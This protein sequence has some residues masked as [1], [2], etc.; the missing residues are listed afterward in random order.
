[1]IN[2][3]ES[4]LKS[5]YE[6]DR[7]TGDFVTL[8]HTFDE[9]KVSVNELGI[10]ETLNIKLNYLFDNLIYLY[11]RSKILTN[12]IPYSYSSWYSVLSA[13]RIPAWNPTTISN[14]DALP[15]STVGW[16]TLDGLQDIVTVPTND[17]KILL[18]GT[19][20]Q[21]VV[22][23][24]INFETT[25]FTVLLS[26]RFI[27]EASQLENGNITD[28]IVDGNRLFSIDSKTNNVILYDI[29]GFV[30]GENIKKN[31]RYIKTIIG[32]EGGRYDNG[33][34]L[35][36]YVGDFY[37]STLVVMDSGNAC[38]K[39]YDKD[40]NWRYSLVVNRIFRE[41]EI[42]DIK[43]KKN[44]ITDITEIYLLAKNNRIIILNPLDSSF[45]V[46][47]FTDETDFREGFEEF[48]IRFV[49][50]KNNTN[51]FYIITNK[52]IY[53]KYFSRPET[54][55]GK[56]N[57]DREF[58]QLYDLK[59][60]DIVLQNLEDSL[61]VYSSTSLLELPLSAGQF[62]KFVEPNFTNDMLFSYNFDLYS[63]DQIKIKPNEYS[64]AAT[65][66]KCILKFI[67]NHYTFLNQ[68]RERFK[69]QFGPY[70]EPCNII[71]IKKRE[72]MIGA[73]DKAFLVTIICPPALSGVDIYASLS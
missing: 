43:L 70:R 73:S 63:F 47:D 59:T 54:K 13:T 24:N 58:L 16:P 5:P 17:G 12:R 25:S 64:Q 32:G 66:N 33:K 35:S 18:I 34:F 45:K 9:I 48:S 21:T 22:F 37:N 14:L 60:M 27:D 61:F 46:I 67:N 6:F 49:F 51:I 31:K 40:L 53:K 41:Y 1:M 38:L 42:V 15:F 55:I 28:L 71:G 4:F 50:S 69:F 19:D 39:F 23:A 36:P 68:A 57:L 11:S 29:E 62:F 56:Y 10:S 8:P 65:F 2:I 26:S 7:V 52:S 30:G 20:G 3:S 72:L 44:K